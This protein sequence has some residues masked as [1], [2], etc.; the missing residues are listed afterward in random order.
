MRSRQ[1][2]FGLVYF[3]ACAFGL[4][5]IAADS[6]GVGTIVQNNVNGLLLLL[7][8][9]VNVYVLAICH[10]WSEA[11]AYQAIQ[12]AARDAFDVRFHWRAWGAAVEQDCAAEGPLT[13]GH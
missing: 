5:W 1:E 2:A 8:A 6:G 4:P 13:D 11:V 3:E 7:D 12:I 9:G 10:V